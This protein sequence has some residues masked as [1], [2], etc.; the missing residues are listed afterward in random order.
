MLSTFNNTEV[1][2]FSTSATESNI[3]RML[4]RWNVS[5]I[6]TA[7]LDLNALTN[8]VESTSALQRQAKELIENGNS[9]A[10]INL[11][12]NNIVDGLQALNVDVKPKLEDL[13][14]YIFF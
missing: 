4:T 8:V 11:F 9:E 6:N 14:L 1:K 7:E 3:G 2:Y 5:I 12:V 10:A 13:Q